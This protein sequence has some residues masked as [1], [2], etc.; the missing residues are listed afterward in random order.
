MKKESSCQYK[1]QKKMSS[2]NVSSTTTLFTCAV[3]L[4]NDRKLVFEDNFAYNLTLSVLSGRDEMYTKDVDRPIIR[5][6][7][8][9]VSV[10][11]ERNACHSA[12]YDPSK[13]KKQPCISHIERHAYPARK[14]SSQASKH[15][16]LGNCRTSGLCW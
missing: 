8:D 15:P 10:L 2:H 5:C 13:K 12:P 14:D 6:C 3:M 7:S 9:T 1:V 16:Y 4:H 11:D